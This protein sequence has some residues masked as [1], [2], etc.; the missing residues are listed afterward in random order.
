MSHPANSNNSSHSEP[1]DDTEGC[2]EFIDVDEILDRPLTPDAGE[3]ALILLTHDIQQ[4]CYRIVAGKLSPV[5]KSY[6]IQ[7]R[8]KIDLKAGDVVTLVLKIPAEMGHYSFGSDL[9]VNPSAFLA[10]EAEEGCFTLQSAAVGAT[11]ST[12][13]DRCGWITLKLLFTVPL[14]TSYSKICKL[15]YSLCFDGVELVDNRVNCKTSHHR[16]SKF[17]YVAEACLYLI[18][19]AV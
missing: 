4:P 15:E 5:K 1:I 6:G 12:V 16:D 11:G 14:N 18:V 10:I 3:S 8:N 17:P 13:D 19:P 2:I 7:L 9:P